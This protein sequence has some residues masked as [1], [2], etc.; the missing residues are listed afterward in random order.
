MHDRPISLS[1]SAMTL[2]M[3]LVRPLAPH[4]R[5]AFMV[6]LAALLRQEPA[7]PP[8]DGIVHRHARALLG[9]GSYWRQC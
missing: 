1:N 2:I 5:T 4:D 7:Q 9:S 6:S 8:G 3:H